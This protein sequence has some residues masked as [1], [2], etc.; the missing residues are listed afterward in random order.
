MRRTRAERQ[1][2]QATAD[3]LDLLADERIARRRASAARARCRAFLKAGGQLA[4]STLAGQVIYCSLGRSAAPF[5]EDIVLEVC[6][7]MGVTPP[8]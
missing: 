1:A 7:K 6:R 8:C 2:L 3:G 4:K 5:A